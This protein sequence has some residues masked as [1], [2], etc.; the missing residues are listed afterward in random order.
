MLPSGLELIPRDASAIGIS[1][2]ASYDMFVPSWWKRCTARYLRE[3]VE[4]NCP[5]LTAGTHTQTVVAI[6]NVPGFYTVPMTTAE[7]PTGSAETGGSGDMNPG[8]EEERTMLGASGVAKKA[9]A[10]VGPDQSTAEDVFF[11]AGL[12]PVSCMARNK[13]IRASCDGFQHLCGG[14]GSSAV[15]PPTQ[16]GSGRLRPTGGKRTRSSY[17]FR[18]RA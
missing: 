10:V 16:S 9:F 5:V 7:V 12:E 1:R 4:W 2:T 14:V 3:A 8:G 11:Q 17:C 6:A 15:P 18:K 13:T